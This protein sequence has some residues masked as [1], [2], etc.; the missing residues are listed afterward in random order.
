MKIL[1]LSILIVILALFGNSAY[2]QSNRDEGIELYRAGEYEKALP[3]LQA[4]VAEEKRD[5]VAWNYLGAVLIKLSKTKKAK[6][7]FAA[8]KGFT[9]RIYL[10]TTG[11]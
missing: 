11:I 5:R 7:H 3:I 1:K 6:L 8:P 10:F 4:R 2:S 9:P